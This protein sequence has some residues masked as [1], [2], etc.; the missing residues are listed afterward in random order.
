MRSISDQSKNLISDTRSSLKREIWEDINGIKIDTSWPFW[1]SRRSSARYM[2]VS[3]D[4][5]FNGTLHLVRKPNDERLSIESRKSA[6]IYLTNGFLRYEKRAYNAAA[7]NY[8]GSH[9]RKYFT[10][11]EF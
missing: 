3:R 5:L 8:T 10:R 6:D 9:K 7:A 11:R 1:Y 4:E 2:S